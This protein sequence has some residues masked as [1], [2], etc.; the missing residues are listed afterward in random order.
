MEGGF[1]A[2]RAG[3]NPGNAAAIDQVVEINAPR[4]GRGEGIIVGAAPGHGAFDRRAQD[5]RGA[6]EGF[7][8][9]VGDEQDAGIGIDGGDAIDP[10]LDRQE[11]RAGGTQIDA[12]AGE[13][14]RLGVEHLTAIG[15]EQA[16]REASVG[17]VGEVEGDLIA[18]G[19]GEGDETGP[20]TG[21][22]GHGGGGAEGGEGRGG[23]VAQADIEAAN[24]R[25]VAGDAEHV[26]AGGQVQQR[27]GGGAMAVGII[28]RAA[29]DLIAARTFQ[30]PDEAGGGG[31]AV[32]QQAGRGV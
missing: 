27:R 8:G 28:E 26:G 24:G 14:E 16:E 31:E 17:G 7:G 5:Q 19:G 25:A 32:E 20:G 6:G 11:I 1:V 4:T 18:G 22:E 13:I 3:E 29:R 21:I 9:G 23:D 15:V 2:A 10:P 30:G 12:V